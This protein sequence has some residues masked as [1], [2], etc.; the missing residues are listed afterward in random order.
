MSY[1]TTTAP[2]NGQSMLSSQSGTTTFNVQGILTISVPLIDGDLTGQQSGLTL[3]NNGTLILSG[4]NT[5]SGATTVGDVMNDS[6]CVLRLVDNPTF[7]SAVTINSPATLELS[8][9]VA[10][11]FA[12]AISG[13]GTLAKSGPG[14]VT[15]TQPYYS[16]ATIVNGGTLLVTSLGSSSSVTV[17]R[18]TTF[19][20]QGYVGGTVTNYN[21][22]GLAA[23][24]NAVLQLNSLTLGVNRTDIQTLTFSGDGTGVDGNIAVNTSFTQNGTNIVSVTGILPLTVPT[25][26]TLISYPSSAAINNGVFVLGSLPMRGAGYLTNDTV[27]GLV[28]LVLTSISAVNPNPTNLTV[29]VSGGQLTLNWPADHTGWTLQ[30]QTNSLATGL[31][32]TWYPVSGSD[33]TNSVT[34]TM[35]PAKPTVFYRLMLNP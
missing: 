17:N 34:F 32:G 22:S 2:T 14:T 29:V 1:I 35:D 16:G 21:G 3:T 12:N 20:G 13:D 6:A 18:G 24:D 31:S 33:T 5:Y 8:N 9:S 10:W 28:Q 4:A 27:N 26:Y 7:A 15:M 23:P 19:G 30:S 25:T 11:T